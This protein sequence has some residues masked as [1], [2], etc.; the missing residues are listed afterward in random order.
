MINFFNA[1]CQGA[2]NISKFGICDDNNQNPAFI[3]ETNLLD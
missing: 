1:Q 3:S 2:T